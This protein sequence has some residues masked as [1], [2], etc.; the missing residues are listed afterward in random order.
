MHSN[1]LVFP[2]SLPNRD[3][4]RAAVKEAGVVLIREGGDDNEFDVYDSSAVF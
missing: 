4:L 1:C 2:L 3:E